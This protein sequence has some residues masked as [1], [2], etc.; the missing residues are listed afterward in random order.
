MSETATRMH[1]PPHPAEVLRDWMP[2]GM[3]VTEAARALRVDRVTL[4]RL[5]NGRCGVSAPMAL[6]LAQWLGTS[7]DLWMG[8]QAQY[9]LWRASRRRL[10]KIEPLRRELAVQQ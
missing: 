8:L 3:T 6:R 7:P 5:L 10:P 9:D 2:P 1:N 4:S